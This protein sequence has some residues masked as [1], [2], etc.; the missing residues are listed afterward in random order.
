M[1]TVEAAREAMA[2]RRAIKKFLHRCGYRLERVGQAQALPDM[3]PVT[4]DPVEALY[5]SGGRPVLVNIP[6]DRLRGLGS[7]AFP[8]VPGGGHPL[9]ETAVAYLQGRCVSYEGSPLEQFSRR[10]RPSS[11]AAAM[12]LP[13][14]EASAELRRIPAYAS[15][16]IPPWGSVGPSEAASRRAMLSH[17]ENAHHGARL[18]VDEGSLVSG[19]LSP[20]KGALEFE[21][22]TRI[23]DSI[24]KRG[25]R[26]SDGPDGDI[27]G[28]MLLRGDDWA[29]HAIQ[30]QHR[31]SALAALGRSHVP[32]RIC[33]TWWQKTNAVR[34]AEVD[35]W[36][37]VRNGLFTRE[38][39]LEIF[40]RIFEGG[41]PA[42]YPS[43][44]ADTATTGP[45][46][47]RPAAI[48]GS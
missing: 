11:A 29:V 28:L 14:R 13:G 2:P 45:G 33:D 40:D 36:P 5:L 22:M 4:E 35:S 16:S 1:R 39:A 26:R 43:S 38:Q 10:W 24:R 34:R 23:I 46:P 7:M 21:R 8:C 20:A 48:T 3:R 12:G 27:K 15:V 18:T 32:V 9:V 31:I 25:Y 19:R 17:Q 41:Q 30:G 47:F 6:L 44:A 37:N 42:G